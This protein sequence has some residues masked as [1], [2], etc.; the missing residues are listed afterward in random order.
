[1][2]LYAIYTSLQ[3]T[4]NVHFLP[5]HLR[6]RDI[7]LYIYRGVSEIYNMIAEL[8][9]SHGSN[10]ILQRHL[11]LCEL[12][13]FLFIWYQGI[14]LPCKVQEGDS[15]S[16][17]CMSTKVTK[18]KTTIFFGKGGLQAIPIH[19]AKQAY[20]NCVAQKEVGVVNGKI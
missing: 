2:N 8:I 10:S 1:M 15:L 3:Y 9:E 4:P 19:D 20:N 18:Q 12:C 5:Q 11:Y 14:L 17:F 16:E 6:S 13:K 7:T